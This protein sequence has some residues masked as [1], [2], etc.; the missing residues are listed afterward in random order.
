MSEA[1]GHHDRRLLGQLD[2]WGGT[3]ARQVAE[4][5]GYGNRRSFSQI[6]R[7]ELDRLCEKGLA[8]R[9]DDDRPI[10]W[11]LTEAGKR[12]IET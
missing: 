1:P 6:T 5:L 3:T 7:M 4:G 12:A 8:K 9:M 10:C 11:L 2:L